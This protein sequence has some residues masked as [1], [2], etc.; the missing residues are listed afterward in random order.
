MPWR[1]IIFGIILAIDRMFHYEMM[2]ILREQEAQTII[3]NNVSGGPHSY[4]VVR[5]SAFE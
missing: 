1:I 2:S 3:A 4:V 5:A